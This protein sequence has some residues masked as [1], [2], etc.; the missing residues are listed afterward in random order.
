M[1]LNRVQQKTAAGKLTDR[2]SP[3][4]LLRSY[5]PTCLVFLVTLGIVAAP[6]HATE[7]F[8]VESFSSSISSNPEGAL[9]TQAGSHPYALTTT[10]MFN[11]E[12]TEEEETY[13]ENAKGEEVPLGEPEVFTQIYGNPRNLEVNLPAGLIIN[14]AATAI[15]CTEA[16]LETR[17]AAGGGCPAASAVGIVTVDIYGDGEKV[18]GAVYNMVPPP[19]V[20]AEFGV[21]PGEVGLVIHIVGHIRTGGDY[22]FSADLSEISQK[23]SIYGLG[24]TLWGAPSEAGHDAQRGICASSGTVQK[25]IEKEFWEIEELAD[26]TSTEEY[27]FDCSSERTDIPLLSMPGA[28]TGKPLETTLS[29]NSWQDSDELESAPATSPP[30][31][32]CEALRFNPTLEVAPAPE[33]TAT[34]E[35]PTGLNIDLRLPHEESPEGRAEADLKQLAV[36]LPPGMAISLS[37]ANGL[38]ACTNTPEPGRPEGEIA[39]HSTEAMLC[40]ES[41]ELGTAE[42]LT[43]LLETPLKGAVYLAQQQAFEGSLIGLYVVLESSGVL[44]KLAGK[45]TLDPNTG[46]VAIALDDVPQ[47]PLGEIKLSLFSGPRA[48]LLTPPACGTYTTTSRLEPWSGGA[49]A[50]PSSEFKVGSGPDGGACPSGAFSP[51]L[52]AG[53]TNTQAGA[54]SPFSVTFARQDGEQR[55][56]GARVAMPPGLLGIIKGVA[57]CPE[58]QAATGACGPESSIGEATVAAGS[59]EDPFWIKGGKVYLTGP[60]N[61]SGA[62]TVGALPGATDPPGGTSS[63]P[64]CAPFGLSIV[65]P[66]IAGPFNLGDVVIRA[67]VEVDPHTAAIT[68]SSD[69]L[70]TIL[71]GVPLDIRTIGVNV[72]RDAFMF[73]PTNC[74]PRTVAAAI[75]SAGAASVGASSSSPA[76]SPSSSSSPSVSSPFQAAGCRSMP[77]KP[78]FSAS[79]AARA[80]KAGGAGLDVKV[81]SKGGPQS[82]GGEA[83]IEKVKVDLPKRLPS[84]LTTLQQACPA[85]VF[86]ANPAACPSGSLVGTATASTPML[87]RPLTGPAYLVSH[88]GLALPDLVIILRGEGIVI[89]LEGQTSIEQGVTSSTFRS[90]PDAPL[91]TFDLVL[92]AGPHSLLAAN[93]PAKARWSL[94]SQT[95][96][97][98]MAITGQNGPVIHQTTKIAVTGCPKKA[99]KTKNAGKRKASEKHRKGR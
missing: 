22:G 47:L 88:G 33:P 80:S 95:L 6:A 2:R 98:P 97:M 82:G 54:F 76:S 27:R 9:A 16:Q 35:S 78:V 99:A 65:V 39:L 69:P 56:A 8:G 63:S 84:R 21:D 83:N 36:T 74:T 34:A 12:V 30:V 86:A 91:S 58:P 55:L 90:L 44:V 15:K 96:N 32:G 13:K 71:Q 5:I 4:A 62:C 3:R 87:A 18:K 29:V 1:S 72:D 75:T 50:E 70:P 67:K 57:Q 48:A 60:Y 53:T 61:G 93:L 52:T 23:V 59:G 46:Q 92:P 40:P 49:P 11:H 41:S 37:A 25:A 14:P 19:G 45:A 68:V 51:S 7:T 43:P 94:C 17:Q 66:A 20:S 73:N 89:D 77:F 28:C 64:G 24:L 10:V 38:G 79:T 42:V 81:S 85:G 26:G 31:T